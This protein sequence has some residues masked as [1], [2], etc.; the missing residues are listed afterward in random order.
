MK[1]IQTFNKRILAKKL[2]INQII[3]NIFIQECRFYAIFI[4]K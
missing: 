3:M 1:P 4:E 2:I